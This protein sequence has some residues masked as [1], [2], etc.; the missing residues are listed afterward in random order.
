MWSEAGSCAYM[1]RAV[2]KEASGPFPRSAAKSQGRLWSHT[3]VESNFSFA[4]SQLYKLSLPSAL[5]FRLCFESCRWDTQWIGKGHVLLKPLWTFSG[6][7]RSLHT[8]EV[9][10]ELIWAALSQKAAL[11]LTGLHQWASCCLAQFLAV[12][13][14]QANTPGSQVRG[15]F[16]LYLTLLRLHSYYVTWAGVTA[17]K[18]MCG[19]WWFSYRWCSPGIMWWATV[20]LPS[21]FF[22][23]SQLPWLCTHLRDWVIMW[24]KVATVLSFFVLNPASSWCLHL[25]PGKLPW[26]GV[27]IFPATSRTDLVLFMTEKRFS[28]EAMI[29]DQA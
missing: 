27:A 13:T 2:Q 25:N 12:P 9:V 5:K 6:G 1:T 11:W 26:L 23:S 19:T 28:V 15:S 7:M 14:F 24:P 18:W 22:P 16:G 21:Q 20:S 3:W 8:E 10:G 29:G 4:S 17:S